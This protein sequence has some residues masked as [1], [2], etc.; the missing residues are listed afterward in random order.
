[1]RS[2]TGRSHPLSGEAGRGG[3]SGLVARGGGVRGRDRGGDIAE[4]QVREGGAGAGGR[5]LGCR[6]D[7]ERGGFVLRDVEDEFFLGG[8]DVASCLPRSTIG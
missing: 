4:A 8:F 3:R 7:G 1:M 6:G 5:V 2:E